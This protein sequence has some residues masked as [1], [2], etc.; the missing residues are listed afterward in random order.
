VG[1]GDFKS[2]AYVEVDEIGL[3]NVQSQEIV[4]ARLGA[5]I[6]VAVLGRL[7]HQAFDSVDVGQPVRV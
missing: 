7:L 3:D 2:S 5:R 6:D 1:G 4:I